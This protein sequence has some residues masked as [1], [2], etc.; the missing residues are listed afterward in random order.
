MSRT[1]TLKAW[2]DWDGDGDTAFPGAYENV[3]VDIVGVDGP[4]RGRSSVF[5]DFSAG[6]MVLTLKN[7]HGNYSPYRQT[8][9]LY[10]FKKA[11]RLMR[12]SVVQD[13]VTKHQFTG[14]TADFNELGKPMGFPT[15]EITA[16]DG[17]EKLQRGSIRTGLYVNKYVHELVTLILDL[18]NWPVGLRALETSDVLVPYF[19]MDNDV[20]P[21][22]AL[23][24]AV[25]QEMGGRL[26]IA[27]D[28]SVTFW[29]R[30][31]VASSASLYTFKTT[32]GIDLRMRQEDFYDR[33]RH[34]R[35]TVRPEA[36]YSSLYTLRSIGTPLVYGD[37]FFDIAFD[38]PAIEVAVPVVDVATETNITTLN[39]ALDA[40]EIDI[41]LTDGQEF[42]EGQVMVI[43]AE[44]ML[45]KQKLSINTCRVERGYNSTTAATHSNG[46]VV[47]RYN[48]AVNTD[49]IANAV[50]DG[51]GTDITNQLSIKTFKADGK[52]AKVNIWCDEA[53]GG[54]LMFF[55]VRG[56]ALRPTGES[57]IVEVEVADPHVSSALFA[58]E[59]SYILESRAIKAYANLRAAISGAPVV[60]LSRPMVGL[61]PKNSA[62]MSA[63][64]SLELGNV[65]RIQNIGGRHPM[66][67]DAEFV[68]ES[69]A[70][71]YSS[72]SHEKPIKL[73][74]VNCQMF[75]RDVAEAALFRVSSDDSSGEYSQITTDAA[76]S[77]DRIAHV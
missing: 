14:Y 4:R 46:Q 3:S 27:K 10:G 77:G 50:I 61:V 28:G 12:F 33:I 48:F 71:D 31:H 62:E 59:F 54:F 73:L 74:G 68:A 13:G 35:G 41:T 25:Q 64:L 56:K 7:I 58:E 69:I 38:Y 1:L 63:L 20:S 53:D 26:F 18:A 37:N 19:W 47:R 23:L 22:E 51:T 76:T 6:Q 29:N 49:Y 34:A 40:V 8:S 36:G 43:D 55:Q 24:K 21:L 32:V 72:Y 2:I 16:Y 44:Q 70:Y 52:N 11:E 66:M 15:V 60:N 5:G 9:P 57:G 39:E 42:E 75:H 45:V 67:L 30:Y 65:L 17:F